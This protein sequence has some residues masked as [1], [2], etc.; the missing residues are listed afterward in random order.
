MTTPSSNPNPKDL[1]GRTKAP[2]SLFPVTA[3]LQGAM[4]LFLGKTKYGRCNWR[5]APVYASVYFEAL[6]RHGYKWW[7][8]EEIDDEDGT[9][10]LG[11]C[12]ACLAIIIDAKICGTLIDDR[13]YNG[14]GAVAEFKQQ[15]HLIPELTAKYAEKHPRH[16]TIA[17]MKPVTITNIIASHANFPGQFDEAFGSRGP[18][19]IPF[20]GGNLLGDR[21]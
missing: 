13:Q 14:A 20:S 18:G 12:L 6:L 8:G 4:A 17:D 15:L 2:I 1:I 7:E 5:A 3:I 16:F 9:T 19:C 21:T 10:H 11:N